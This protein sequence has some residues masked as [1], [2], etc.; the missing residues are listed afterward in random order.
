LAVATAATVGVTSAAV[1]DS[2]STPVAAAPV[3][4]HLVIAGESEVG[5]PWTPAAMACDSYCFVR[6][7]T[8]FDSLAAF[9]ADGEVHGVLAESIEPNA[10]Y[11]EWTIVVRDG[12]SFTDGTPLNADAVIDN[13][14]AGAAGLVVGG[15]L[16]D[17]AKFPDPE[18][19][20]EVRLKIDKVDEMTLTIY[21]GDDGDA[22][23]PLPWRDFPH[24]LTGQWG[25]IASPRWLAAVAD[26]TS[27]AVHPVGSGPFV[28]DTFEPGSSMTVRRNPDYWMT[29]AAGLQLPYLDSIEFRVIEDPET[30]VEGL[31]AGDVDLV[32]TSNG[33]AIAAAQDLGD[34]VA[35][36]LQQGYLDTLYLLIDHDKPG[37]LQDP[38]VRCAMSLAIDRDEFNEVT[39]RGISQS[40]NGLF[41][42]GQEGYLDDNGLS[43]EQDLDA[44]RAMI[45]AYE[46][47]TDTEVAFTLGRTPTNAFAIAAELL[48]GWWSGIGIDADERAIPQERLHPHGVA[49]R[50]RVRGDPL[51]GPRWR[52]AR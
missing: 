39:T 25:L 28:V 7:R 29:D 6:A 14:Q 50:A 22:E 9:G 40:A 8:F 16:K 41:S 30:S 5:N 3:G 45:A 47:E 38:R 49:R 12:I 19:P 15:F 20:G 48:L 27:L 43:L 33:A 4:G 17:V 42:P 46:S 18:A 44:A 10:D 13:L 52:A 35:V 36:T 31:E 1:T 34:D 32:T 21:T 37:P 26:D 24:M 51:A 2:T 23:R 11:T